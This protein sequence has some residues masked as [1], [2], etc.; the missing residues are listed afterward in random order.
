MRFRASPAIVF[1]AATLTAAVVGA[2]DL[3]PGDLL[4]TR[5]RTP[6]VPAAVLRVDPVSGA[7]TIV[8]LLEGR[9]T[10]PTAIAID[11]DGRLF[12]T[13]RSLSDPRGAGAIGENDIVEVDPVTG[14][15]RMVVSF[16]D[17][18]GAPPVTPY[19]IA[20]DA[21]GDLLVTDIWGAVLR[22]DPETGADT[23]VAYGYPLM[24]PTGIA[25]DATGDL[26]VVSLGALLRIDPVTGD[27]STITADEFRR[28]IAL[29]AN[30]DAVVAM[31]S[32]PLRVCVSGSNDG[33]SCTHDGE[34]PNGRCRRL[35][36]QGDSILR[37]DPVTGSRS[38]IS[39]SGFARVDGLAIDARGDVFVVQGFPGPI[40]RV[41]PVT[42]DQEPLG[43][44]GEVFSAIAVV[45][46]V[47]IALDI[48]PGSD[49]NSIHPL[50]KGVIPVAVLGSD[51][52]YV[53]DVDMTT[54]AFGPWGAP[55][56]HKKGGHLEDVN[57]DGL[58]DLVSHYPT[59]EAGIAPGDVQ[60][61]VTGES[62]DGTP[63]E[64]CDDI[65]TV[66]ACGIGLELLLLLP[67]LQ[68]WRGR[69]RRP[70]RREMRAP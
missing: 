67:P 44:G 65:A 27:Q 57:D 43:S 42:G 30:G 32:P 18:L 45:P 25:I 70:I 31:Q 56:Q 29:D 21:G 36:P 62:L 53:E 52:F 23:L 33:A 17:P 66:P 4:V 20:I 28:G 15:Q 14:A 58:T 50:R 60:A 61:C 26:L 63:F 19:G 24:R 64:G 12:V 6:E 37:V 1:L 68:Y 22:V 2:A 5:S 34:C 40:V 49:P 38:T 9:E 13:E 48:E 35:P 59:E 51:T 47:E 8:A 3:R 11:R 41:D 10:T 16:P 69:R 39:S 55:P 46:G 54:L 7:Q